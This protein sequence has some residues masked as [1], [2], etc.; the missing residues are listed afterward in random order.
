MTHRTAP[1]G[2]DPDAIRSAWAELE[3]ARHWFQVCDPDLTDAAIYRWLAAEERLAA[4]VA[5]RPRGG[6]VAR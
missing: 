6:E 4:L 2:Y 1:D 5:Q 3:D